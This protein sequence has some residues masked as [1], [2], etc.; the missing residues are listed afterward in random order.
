M[1][2]S[3]PPL[4]QFGSFIIIISI[5]ARE[6]CVSLNENSPLRSRR[7]PLERFCRSSPTFASGELGM[8]R[9]SSTPY[10]IEQILRISHRS[11]LSQT[12]WLNSCESRNIVL[13][14]FAC[15]SAL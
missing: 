3:V 8:G 4:N 12:R 11:A 6:M 15:E 10:L 5:K 7:E 1:C 13:C 9:T 2:S 14:F